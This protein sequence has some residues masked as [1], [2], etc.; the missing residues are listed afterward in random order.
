MVFVKI[1]Y[2]DRAFV[3]AVSLWEFEPYTRKSNSTN[4]GHWKCSAIFLR[5]IAEDKQNAHQLPEILK[6]EK[7]GF[8]T[9]TTLSP[10]SIETHIHIVSLTH[11]KKTA[12]H[13]FV[14]NE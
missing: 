14:M 1:L 13:P 10:E 12:H 5:E 11:R 6:R 7:K 8:H 9:P 3:L 4:G 2:E